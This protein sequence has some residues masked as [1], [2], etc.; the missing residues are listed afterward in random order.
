MVDLITPFCV[1]P[2]GGPPPRRLC[3]PDGASK[4][5]PKPA[6]GLKILAAAQGFTF[7][8][9]SSGAILF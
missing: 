4:N 5:R 6:K 3:G 8:L 7:R 2:E 1:A 9:I